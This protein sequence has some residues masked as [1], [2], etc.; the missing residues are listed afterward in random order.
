MTGPAGGRAVLEKLR[1]GLIVSVQA[2]DGSA[3]DRSDVLAAMA[4]A[5]IANK[6]VGIRAR[7]LACLTTMRAAFVAPLIGLV[8]VAY[9]GFEPF[10]TPTIDDVRAVASTGADI[11]AFD[12]T[13]RAR[14][15]GSTIAD[16]VAAAVEAGR[17]AMADCATFDDALRASEAG[18]H[19]VATTLSGYTRETAGR[20]LPDL[21]LVERMSALDTF[22][23]CEGGVH[24]PVQLREA[25]KHGADA[26]VV[27][28]AITNV[29]W[30]V[31]R[32]VGSAD[33]SSERPK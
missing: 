18:A 30:L 28:T 5:A 29:D 16:L 12:A 3:I 7:G 17:L 15:D 10:I 20:V 6:A 31:Q 21:E 27:G 33:A 1:G 22:V 19:I 26:V 11:V 23:V 25:L 8:K 4:Q 32:F 24:D 2:Y 9:E 13:G 14:P